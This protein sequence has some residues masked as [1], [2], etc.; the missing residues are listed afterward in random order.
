MLIADKLKRSALAMV[1]LGTTAVFLVPM[2]VPAVLRAARPL[3]KEAVKGGMLCLRQS[4]EALGEACKALDGVVAEARAELEAGRSRPAPKTAPAGK[5]KA[6]GA[7]E[8]DPE[9]LG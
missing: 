6:P 7:G 1:G 2:L 5:G 4:R 8:P 3:V 9:V